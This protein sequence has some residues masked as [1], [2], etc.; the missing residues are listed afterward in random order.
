MNVITPIEDS[1]V[2]LIKKGVFTEAKLF[3]RGNHVFA[4]IR[5]GKAEFARLHTSKMTSVSN[6]YWQEAH[7]NQG[8]IRVVGCEVHF[9]PNQD[10]PASSNKPKATTPRAVAA[11]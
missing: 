4:E 8:E 2:L 3:F 5:P 7:T 9:I 10:D 6:I 1:Y 11:K